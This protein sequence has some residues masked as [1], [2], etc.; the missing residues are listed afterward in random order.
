MNANDAY[1]PPKAG[2]LL[3]LGGFGVHF[4]IRGEQ[5]GGAFAI[6]EHPMQPHV[7]VE[8]HVHRIEDELSYVVEGTIWARVGEREV[9]APSGSYVW[10]PRGVMHSFWN[11]GP[12]PARVLE[13]ISPA[14]FERLFEEFAMLLERTPEPSEEEVVDLCDQYGLTLDASWIADLEARFGAM[15]MV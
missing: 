8:P 7:I 13:V 3:D 15:R 4:K 9:E 11:P 2:K 5:T 10:K 6:V 14:G 12:N 1:L